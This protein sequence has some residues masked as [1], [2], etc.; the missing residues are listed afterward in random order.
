M[1]PLKYYWIVWY[2]DDYA[3][4]QFDPESGEENSWKDID[5]SSVRMISWAQF[6]KKLSKKVKI[7]TESV[8]KPGMT[9]IEYDPGDS[10]I[11]ARRNHVQIR[12]VSKI[13]QYINGGNNKIEYI[14]GKNGEELIKL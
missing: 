12:Y 11:I 5:Q 3:V 4:P 7:P 6:S 9:S 1:Q 8:R 10:I 2:R 13:D 14:L